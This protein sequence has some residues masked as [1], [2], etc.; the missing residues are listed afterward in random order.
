MSGQDDFQNPETELAR[1]NASIRRYQMIAKTTTDPS[2][3]RRVKRILTKLKEYRD[4]IV[5]LFQFGEDR[6]F[7]MVGEE[8]EAPDY[9]KSEFL[10]IILASGP[11]RTVTDDVIHNLNLYMDFFDIEFLSFF[12][13]R[14]LKLDF[15][16]SI[17]RDNAHHK[18]MEIKRRVEDFEREMIRLREGAY[19]KSMEQE[20]R[21]RNIKLERTL[22]IEAHRYFLWVREF[23]DVLITD[24][25][26]EGLKCLNGDDLITFELN[27]SERYCEGLSVN[28]A[29]RELYRFTDEVIEFLN[30]PDIEA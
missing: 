3:Q 2:Q 10:S 24:L 16:F 27:E 8:S 28:Q 23:A 20:I 12:S 4:R 15:K 13:E 17:D 11:D 18:F 25:E 5:L 29:L 30:I 14:K 19:H 7:E 9:P 21:L 6:D 22:C 1:L 26:G